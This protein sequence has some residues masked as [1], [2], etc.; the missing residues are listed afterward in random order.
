MED[1]G[2]DG[3][4]ILSRIFRTVMWEG[5]GLDPAGFGYGKVTGTCECSNEPS[6]FIKS[7]E[8]FN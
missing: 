4:V 7:G 3:S 1:P 5:H 2:V 6:G 8:F